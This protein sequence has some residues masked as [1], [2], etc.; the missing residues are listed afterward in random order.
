VK[1]SIEVR[2]EICTGC[3]LCVSS[4]PFGAIRLEDGTAFIGEACTLCGACESS[5]PFGAILIRRDT[6]P[7]AGAS[8]WAGTLVVVE[9]RD[10]RI[11]HSSLELLGAARRISETEGGPVSAVLMT[12]AAG[13]VPAAL[14]AY[15][16]DRVFLVEHPS[17]AHYH[18]EPAAR[19]LVRVINESRPAVVLAAATT[20]GRDLMPRVAKVLD[21]GLTADCTGLEYDTGKACLLQTRPAFGGNIM[22]T[23]ICERTRPQMATVRPRVMKALDPDSGRAG[24]VVTIVPSDGELATRARVREFIPVDEG[25]ADIAEAQVIVSGGRGVKAP[26]N[27]ALIGELAR[28]LEGS[29]GASRAAVDSGWIPYPHQVGQTGKTV[30]P[31][32]YIACGISGAVQHRVGMQSSDRI[33]AINRDETAPIFQFCDAGFVGDLFEIIP[34]LVKEIRRRRG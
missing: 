4:C 20:T 30:Q 29:V 9:Q 2:G 3:G 32:V 28:L 26:E 1:A 5:C 15:G 8:D 17:L 16:A 27:F 11:D 24:S 10:G 12:A 13:D 22:A 19:L 31:K 34:A 18:T 33:Y 23:I 7:A 25:I 21:T 14:V 6:A